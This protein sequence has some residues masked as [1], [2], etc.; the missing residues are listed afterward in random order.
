MARATITRKISVSDPGDPLAWVPSPGTFANIS[1]NTMM[2]VRPSGWPNSD[3]AGPFSNW[4]GGIFAPDFST[5]GAYVVHGSG[6]LSPGS[7]LWA[8]VWCF[9]LSTMQW[10]GRNVPG[11]PIL[12]NTTSLNSYGES[13]EP[14]SLGH[15][16]A[17]HTYDGL[18]YLPPAHGGGTKG[19]LL[20][21]SMA[22]SV[23]G[24]PVH[25][26]DLSSAS[27]PPERVVDS[28]GGTSYPMV[29]EDYARGGLWYLS[30]NGTGP[31]QFIDFADWSSTTYSGV[32]YNAYGDQ[33][34]IYIP[35]PYDCLVGMGRD[36][37]GGV[38]MS[39][40]ICPIVAGVP[41]GFSSIT[42][43]GTPPADRRCGGVWST[44]LDCIVSY[45]AAGSATVHKLTIAEN[46]ASAAWTSETLTGAGGATPGRTSSA[47]NGAW[48]R[49]VEV[50][51]AQC[52]IWCDSVGG[53]VQAWR[54]T[55]PTD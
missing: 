43:S 23:W 31:L 44:L 18:A 51:A 55:L 42:P 25:R 9:D 15:T 4:S 35:P 37:T 32:E 10:V 33:S 41:Q 16:T 24:T 45:Q 39:V 3:I 52:F 19:S 48:S 53:P 29:A 38:N 14:G 49:F 46:L 30:G 13:E 17:P 6:H 20:R 26:F 11:A 40:R 47:D 2:D 7:P 50:P 12:E 8:G 54:L 21:L 22:G 28:L 34:L 27:A 1:Q 5:L 36:G